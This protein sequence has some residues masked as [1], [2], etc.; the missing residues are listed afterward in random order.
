MPSSA[1][2]F[3]YSPLLR[4]D[5]IARIVSNAGVCFSRSTI[6][7]STLP[8]PGLFQKDS[9]LEFGKTQPR[10]GIHLARLFEAVALQ[11]ED[12]NAPPRV[13]ATGM[14]RETACCGCSA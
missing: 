3:R 5:P 13:S 4:L 14:P 10:V 1:E 11:V 9:Q 8:E 2:K 6:Q 12:H 7:L